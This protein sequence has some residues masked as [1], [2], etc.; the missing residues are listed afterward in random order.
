MPPDHAPAPARCPLPRAT[1]CVRCR[2]QTLLDH[3]H[4]T[5][6]NKQL[7]NPWRGAEA[8]HF[9]LLAQRQ[10]FGTPAI[11]APASPTGSG[12]S[13][14]GGTPAVPPNYDA[15]MRTAIRLIEYE[16]ILDAK[17]IY[18]LVGTFGHTALCTALHSPARPCTAASAMDESDDTL[19]RVCCV[20]SF[21]EFLQ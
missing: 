15:A 20:H 11:P 12:S 14:V 18:S 7:D 19:C 10:L 8:Y 5:S 1:D 9:W 4:L 3:D 13:G 17:E 2:L 16:E 21:D 6:N